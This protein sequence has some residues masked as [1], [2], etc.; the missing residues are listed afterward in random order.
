MK[1]AEQ[2]QV[3]AKE[4]QAIYDSLTTEQKIGLATSRRGVSKREVERLMK[5][6]KAPAKKKAK[7]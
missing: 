3:E 1:R 5:E 6:A 4:R 2:R 7:K